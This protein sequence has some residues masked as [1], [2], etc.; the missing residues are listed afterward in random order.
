MNRDLAVGSRDLEIAKFTL[1]DDSKQ[2]GKKS[3]TF[4]AV[5][6]MPLNVLL[7]RTVVKWR[8]KWATLDD[9]ITFETR[10]SEIFLMKVKS[11]R[12]LKLCVLTE[13]TLTL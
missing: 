5:I 12:K 11:I 9:W 4:N 1:P 2:S 7:K 8:F 3:K 13:D 10:T 6:N